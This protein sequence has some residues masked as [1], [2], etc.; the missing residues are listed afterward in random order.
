MRVEP[1]LFFQGRCEEALEFYA[2]AVGAKIEAISRFRDMP[3]GPPEIQNK[4]MHAAV[5][6]GTSTVLFSDGQ[7]NGSLSFDGFSLSL[8]VSDD[9]EAERSFAALGEGGQVRVPLSPTPF[10]SRFGMVVDRFGVLWTVVN[11]TA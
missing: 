1:Y 6:I 11:Q 4:V 9:A 2:G 7:S 10:A 8:A 3:G 5:R